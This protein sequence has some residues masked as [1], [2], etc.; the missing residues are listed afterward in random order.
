[1]RAEGSP[2]PSHSSMSSERSGWLF[3]PK[4]MSLPLPSWA[5]VS[6]WKPVSH[7]RLFV[8]PWP[9][10]SMESSRPDYQSGQPIPSPADL[11][12][13]GIEPG[14]P[15]PQADSLPTKLLG[16]PGSGYIQ[17]PF[18]S[19]LTHEGQASVFLKP[20]SKHTLFS[21]FLNITTERLLLNQQKTPEFLASRREEFNLGPE[22][23]LD[24]SELLCKKVLLKYK[25]DRESFWHRHQKGAE[26]IPAC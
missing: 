20:P 17:Y 6:E 23:R 2:H 1:M 25:R 4:G 16:K 21:L 13:P 26:R 11:P 19:F 7:V 12:D 15:A 5:L 22:T 8:T 3:H 14:S 10:Q 18:L 9:I 24:R